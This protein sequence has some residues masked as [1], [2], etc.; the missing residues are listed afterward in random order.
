M[1][2]LVYLQVKRIYARAYMLSVGLTRLSALHLSS[3][4]QIEAVICLLECHVN[5]KNKIYNE[6]YL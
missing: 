5:K 2:Y 3:Y 1:H 4:G 6:D